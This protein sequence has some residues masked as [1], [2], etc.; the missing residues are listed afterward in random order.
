MA[1]Q[2]WDPDNLNTSRGNSF[3][4]HTENCTKIVTKISYNSVEGI[5]R[6]K[7]VTECLYCRAS[8][9]M[10]LEQLAQ[11]PQFLS[12]QFFVKVYWQH[13]S[14]GIKVL[15]NSVGWITVNARNAKLIGRVGAL[16]HLIKCIRLKKF[17]DGI[18]V[19]ET[20]FKKVWPRWDSNTQSSDPK[21][22][23]I[24]IR[25]RGRRWTTYLDYM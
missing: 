21:S 23:A 3:A 5:S 19:R 11:G 14:V 2:K 25:P 7:I 9:K 4:E 10:C 15:H 16:L 13:A 1:F 17:Y 12:P 22:D 8:M 20:Q 6:L 24:S 18:L